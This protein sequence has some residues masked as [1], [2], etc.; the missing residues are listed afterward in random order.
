MWV[1]YIFFFFFC[2]RK[3]EKI[4]K[5]MKLKRHTADSGLECLHCKEEIVSNSFHQCIEFKTFLRLK[6]DTIKDHLSVQEVECGNDC[7]RCYNSK[8]YSSRWLCVKRN[9]GLEELYCGK[10]M[11][12]FES[13][14]TICGDCFCKNCYADRSDFLNY[15]VCQKC[16]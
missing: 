5:K 7:E 6:L 11:K 14:E 4:K 2:R 9:E 3:R 10:C 1:Y 16:N 12:R 15:C 8:W 13:N